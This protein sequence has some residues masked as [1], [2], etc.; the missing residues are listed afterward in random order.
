MKIRFRTR[1]GTITAVLLALLLLV[2]SAATPSNATEIWSDDF[3][4]G[5]YEGWVTPS[6]YTASEGVL[7]AHRPSALIYRESTVSTGTWR[8][9]LFHVLPC[10]ENT[11]IFFMS[12]EP[13]GPQWVAY[14]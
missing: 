3:E 6:S 14:A 5:D 2:T 4:D 1:A 9:D 8:F 7:R 11:Y 12:S 10:V 13:Q